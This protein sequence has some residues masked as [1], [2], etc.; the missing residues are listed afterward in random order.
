MISL[1]MVDQTEPA[2]IYFEK[3]ANEL[4][5]YDSNTIVMWDYYS[6]I[7][8]ISQV[9][10]LPENSRHAGWIYDNSSDALL[11]IDNDRNVWKMT[12]NVVIYLDNLNY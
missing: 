11:L 2:K 10:L 5:V 12:K 4:V 1:A 7:N 8:I 9:E 6:V 3:V